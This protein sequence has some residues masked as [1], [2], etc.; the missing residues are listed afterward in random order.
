MKRLLTLGIIF[1]VAAL[2]LGPDSTRAHQDDELRGQLTEEFHQTYALAPG[3]R[4]AL[5][6]MNGGV[7]VRS[8]ERNEVRVDAVK[9]AHV[10]ERL[11]EAVIRVHATPQAVQIETD[12]TRGNY[13]WNR[14]MT[15]EERRR[16]QPATVEYTLT[17]PRGARVDEIKLINGGIDVEGLD[18]EVVASS[19]NG[20]VMGRSLTGQLKLSTINGRLEVV[21]DRLDESKPVSLGSV[22]GP[23][24]VTIPSDSNAEVRASTVHGSI[25]NDFGLPVKRGD[26]VGND[27]AGQLGRGGARLRLSNVNGSINVRRA[28]DGRPQSPVTN[29]LSATSDEDGVEYHDGDEPEEARQAVREAGREVREAARETRAAAREIQREARAAAR[30]A[31]KAAGAT[32]GVVVIDPGIHVDADADVDVDVDVEGVHVHGDS[33]QIERVTNTLQTRAERPRIRVE[34]FGGPVR[35]SAWDKPEVM[36]TA[37]K[38]AFDE[39]EMKGIKISTQ[40]SNSNTTTNRPGNSSTSAT[41]DVLIKTEFD[42]AFSHQIIK[43]GDKTEMYSSNASVEL[44]LFVPRNSLLHI[45]SNDGGLRVDGVSGELDLRT[46]DGPIEVSRGAGR[47]SARTGDG[48]IHV[49]DFNGATDVVTGDGRIALEGAFTSL[50]AR[51]G[52]GTITL[53]IPSNSNATIETSAPTVVSDGFAVEETPGTEGRRVRRWRVGGGGAQ[54]YTLRTG[55]GQIIIRRR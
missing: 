21:L 40:S 38:R 43:R 19:I 25:R 26:Y 34:N 13:T 49:A 12:Y 46:G 15:E 42:V 11:D 6:N 17:I 22:N 9:Y 50:A 7:K 32:A 2:M 53:S 29:M 4:V 48:R 36:Y 18:G 33:R 1:A 14:N 28:Q 27:L 54:P 3:G 47:L 8:W 51:T 45:V 37:I 55:D 52:D 30:E 41:S 10:K 31:R 23:V 5:E 35:I 16:N 44:E 24:Y 20:R 39:R